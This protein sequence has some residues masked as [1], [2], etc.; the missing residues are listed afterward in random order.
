MPPKKFT[1]PTG[2]LHPEITLPHEQSVELY[3]NSL[4]LCSGKVRVVLA[5]KNIP[6]KANHIHLIETGWYQNASP[7][8]LKIN[9][10]ATVPVLV[11]DGHPVY[12][13]HDQVEYAEILGNQIN[14]NS[15]SL[16]P[17]PNSG[18]VD[19]C[20]YWTAKTVLSDDTDMKGSLGNC[21]PPLTFIIFATM[22]QNIEMDKIEYGLK[23]HPMPERVGFF[24]LL[25]E[26]GINVFKGGI[27]NLIVQAR[28]QMREHLVEME[29]YFHTPLDGGDLWEDDDGTFNG[30]YICGEQFTTADVG[31]MPI[32]ERLEVGGWNF[33]WADL[34]GITSYW[35]NLK[36]RPSYQLAFKDHE[37]ENIGFARE[38]IKRWKE[39]NPW[40]KSKL[41]DD[42][43]GLNPGPATFSTL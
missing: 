6:Y 34:P 24:K 23:H 31:M 3:H 26:Q 38:E 39:E 28:N 37:I 27:S 14:K 1:P 17:A 4:S 9:P 36:S 41:E 30:P 25:K 21:I 29:T 10:G 22:V 18:F 2:G 8:F 12:E 5:E 11:H 15:P 7:E 33:L 43:P 35:Q 20:E 32:F 42:V 16:K 19:D 13:S 40:F